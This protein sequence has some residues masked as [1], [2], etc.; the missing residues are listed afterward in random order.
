M[1][2]IIT[3]YFIAMVRAG[4]P[5]PAPAAYRVSAEVA[6]ATRE[7]VVQQVRR[8]GRN[9]ALALLWPRGV[10]ERAEQNDLQ[11]SLARPD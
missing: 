11:G 6:G 7:R 4:M 2:S 9:G 5:G 3:R 8:H 1:C 10:V